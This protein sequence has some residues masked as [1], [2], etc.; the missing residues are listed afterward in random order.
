[1]PKDWE[2]LRRFGGIKGS[3]LDQQPCSSETW[4]ALPHCARG[5]R[6]NPC[7]GYH[8]NGPQFINRRG[9]LSS[10][11]ALAAAPAIVRSDSL[12]RIIPRE[13]EVLTFRG[14][15]AALDL[16]HENILLTPAFVTREALAILE[17]HLIFDS[18]LKIHRPSD[19]FLD[20]AE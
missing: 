9:F 17:K 5:R 12:M 3:I 11:L 8:K 14:P 1:M 7:Q 2:F 13:V 18:L 20:F 6:F 15:I 10:C 4:R 16:A 19:E